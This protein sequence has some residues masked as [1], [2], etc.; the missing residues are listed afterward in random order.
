MVAEGKIIK[1]SAY[2]RLDGPTTNLALSQLRDRRV[3]LIDFKRDPIVNSRAS[4][5]E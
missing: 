4:L 1:L 5:S 3:F 2:R